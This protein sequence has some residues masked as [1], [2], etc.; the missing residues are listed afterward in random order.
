M[1][2]SC[3]QVA[4]CDF[5]AWELGVGLKTLNH[6]KKSCYENFKRA[7]DL[8]RFLDKRPKRQNIDMRLGTWNV[9]S[10]YRTG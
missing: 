9:R 8:E 7:S 6:K 10:F 5:P 4:R 2:G 3:G 1:E